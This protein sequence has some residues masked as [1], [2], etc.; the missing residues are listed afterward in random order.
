MVPTVKGV[1]V[2]DPKLVSL[3]E[4]APPVVI[5]QVIADKEVV[6]GDRQERRLNRLNRLNELNR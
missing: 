4:Q 5:E 2:I 6:F 1:V 3:N